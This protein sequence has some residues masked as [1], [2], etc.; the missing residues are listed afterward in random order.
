MTNTER[1]I[2]YFEEAEKHNALPVRFN[3][4]RN[5]GNAPS[6]IAALRRRG[7]EVSRGLRCYEITGRSPKA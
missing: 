6:V 3:V 4:G 5:T 7:F 1:L 2:G